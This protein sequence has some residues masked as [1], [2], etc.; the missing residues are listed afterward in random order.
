MSTV[1]KVDKL[2]KLFVQVV[3]RVSEL[4]SNPEDVKEYKTLLYVLGRINENIAS[5]RHKQL[6]DGGYFEN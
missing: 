2:N 4:E 1:N 5:K 3:S 6:L